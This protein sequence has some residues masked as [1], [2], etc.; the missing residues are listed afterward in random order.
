MALFNHGT[1][2][3][4][5]SFAR[6]KGKGFV[7]QQAMLE[8]LLPRYELVLPSNEEEM[9]SFSQPV[10][11]EIGFGTG[12]HLLL[13]AEKNPDI[14]F[15]GCEPYLNGV[16]MLVKE[17]HDRQ[18]NNIKIY[19]DD[20]R[21]LF[22]KFPDGSIDKIFMLFPDPWPKKKHHKRRLLNHETVDMMERILS[23]KGQL[24]LATDHHDYGTWMLSHMIKHQNFTWTAHAQKD[25]REPP[26]DWVPT[27]Y[28]QKAKASGNHVIWYLLYEKA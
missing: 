11:I 21:K 18:L 24:Q 15:I 6:R 16:A 19:P 13:Q 17:I 27:R 9:F 20:V 3:W 4:L 23:K 1:Q 8:E 14:L 10:Q 5:M 22:N 26:V 12:D 2:P 28:E 7:R 25:W